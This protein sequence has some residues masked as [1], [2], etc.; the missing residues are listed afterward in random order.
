MPS[1]KVAALRQMVEEIFAEQPCLHRGETETTRPIV[2]E[3]SSLP[4]SEV[5]RLMA[6]PAVCWGVSREVGLYLFDTVEPEWAT[7]E[8]GAGLTTLVFALRGAR[9]LAVTPNAHEVASIKKY[10]RIKH[11]AINTVRFVVA[12]SEDYLPRARQA[13]LDFVLIDGKH[14][15]PWPTLDWFFTAERLRQGGLVMVDDCALPGVAE[16]K[17]FLDADQGWEAVAS[18]EGKT[19]VY[20]KIAASVREVAWHMQWLKRP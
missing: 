16:L 3:E 1:P 4:A 18:F 10:A 6:R 13:P 15:Y 9:H 8:T 11:I 14:A 5:H 19:V 17:D 12:A 20:R 2:P 7:L